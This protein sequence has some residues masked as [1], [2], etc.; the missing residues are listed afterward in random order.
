MTLWLRAL[1]LVP[2]ALA[3][4]LGKV[5]R[6][7]IAR[8]TEAGAT[9]AERAVLLE[10]AGKLGDFVYRRLQRSGV[11]HAAGND[12]YYFSPA[13]YEAYRRRRRK[14]ALLV[15]TIVLVGIALYYRGDLS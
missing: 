7:T 9:T 4:R 15:I 10:S 6:R 5:E 14:R 12:R 3:A 13:A 8:V 11:L 2:L 1:T